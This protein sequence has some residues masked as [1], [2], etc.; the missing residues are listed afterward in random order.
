MTLPNYF[1]NHFL[2]VTIIFTLLLFGVTFLIILPSAREIRLIRKQVLEERMRL[3]KLYMRGQLQKR[4]RENY[5][6]IKES[7]DWLD[8]IL[9]KENQELQYITALESIADKNGIKLKINVGE[10]VKMEGFP[11]STL[12]ISLD[13]VGSWPQIML[14]LNDLENLPYYTNIKE[15]VF[16]RQQG[17]GNEQTSRDISATVSAQTF[18]LIL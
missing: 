13:L 10:S 3:E 11:F 9:L 16:A 6:S 17:F 15:I 7:A 14:F 1:K 5:Y 12:N 18:W 2:V 4:V 8:N